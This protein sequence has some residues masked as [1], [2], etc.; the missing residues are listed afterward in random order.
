MMTWNLLN[1]IQNTATWCMKQFKNSH[2]IW[3]WTKMKLSNTPTKL[4]V[5]PI[6]KDLL[7][8]WVPI[9]RCYTCTLPARCC[10][11]PTSRYRCNC[12][13]PPCCWNCI[14]DNHK[15]YVISASAYLVSTAETNQMQLSASWVHRQDPLQHNLITSSHFFDD[16][17]L[18][19]VLAVNYRAMRT[20]ELSSGLSS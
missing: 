13:F 16:T 11:F 9:A 14:H 8:H 18:C 4:Q 2:Q 10:T 3:P 5:S 7:R 17:I 6:S 15:K 12:P 19:N 20:W 1:L